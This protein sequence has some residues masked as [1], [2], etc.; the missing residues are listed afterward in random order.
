[1]F[2]PTTGRPQQFGLAAAAVPEDEA[3][4]HI[5]DAGNQPDFGP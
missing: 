2:N 4:A 1:M 5:G 3:V